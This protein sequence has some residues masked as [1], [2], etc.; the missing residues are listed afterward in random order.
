M[1]DKLTPLDK[2]AEI[3][4]D[5]WMN[6]RDDEEFSDFIEYNDLALPISYAMTQKIVKPQAMAET[7][8]DESFEL[9]LSALEIL[10]DEGFESLDDLFSI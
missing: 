5:L 2:R 4:A 7:L 10:Q 1:T 6:Y 9:L 3:L 8:I